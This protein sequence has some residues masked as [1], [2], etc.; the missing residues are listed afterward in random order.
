MGLAAASTGWATP[1]EWAANRD[2]IAGLYIDDKRKLKD[3][4]RI[5]R[6]EH[7]FHATEKMYKI[8]LNKWGLQKYLR[9]QTPDSFKHGRRALGKQA[10]QF[11]DRTLPVQQKRLSI[12]SVESGATA[13][14]SPRPMA[15]RWIASPDQW[16]LPEE[17][18]FIS[19]NYLLAA[20]G[21]GT[22]APPNNKEHSLTWMMQVAI[23]SNVLSRDMT[24]QGF[25][26]LELC[27]ENFR[28]RLAA[29][30]PHLLSDILCA[31]AQLSR[32]SDELVTVFLNYA[33]G[34]CSIL[35]PV[36]H[37][38]RQL[39]TNLHRHGWA[40]VKPHFQNI[41]GAY[42]KNARALGDSDDPYLDI[43]EGQ[44]TFIGTVAGWLSCDDAI[45][46]MQ[47][48]LRR[49]D[50]KGLHDSQVKQMIQANLVLMLYHAEQFE[51]ARALALE[52][53]REGPHYYSAVTNSYALLTH[54]AEHEENLE[55]AIGWARQNYE[56]ALATWGP[57]TYHRTAQAVL[58]LVMVLR[59]ANQ[60]DEAKELVQGFD[61]SW[62]EFCEQLEKSLIKNGKRFRG[63][64]SLLHIKGAR[65][66]FQQAF[67]EMIDG[68]ASTDPLIP[69]PVSTSPWSCS[70]SEGAESS[71]SFVESYAGDTPGSSKGF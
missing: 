27:F 17:C 26:M 52:I 61:V 20:F 43:Q 62:D 32:S 16:K 33:V 53:I 68:E 4:M 47:V 11:L 22:W 63:R 60:I 1:E 14:T 30:E 6:D 31:V 55:E 65:S 18:I 67:N 7:A 35:C 64:P 10:E 42:W 41:L 40:N 66:R 5:M 71:G 51:A 38:V 46:T 9:H 28:S 50:E 69:S 12:V 15:P 49:R 56:F 29:A 23:A 58:E 54:I 25:S 3:V 39:L 2:I 48:V 45:N 70:V 8:R 36:N 24:E 19:H 34:L 13:V 59:K 57:P 44:T 37:P 21:N